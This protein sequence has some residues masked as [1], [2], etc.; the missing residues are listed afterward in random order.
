[1]SHIAP[2]SPTVI[3]EILKNRKTQIFH[4]YCITGMENKNFEK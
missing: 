2:V 1:M 4:D 3:D